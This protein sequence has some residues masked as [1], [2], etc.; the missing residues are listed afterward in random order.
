VHPE[1]WLP[2]WIGVAAGIVL[3][4]IP[5]AFAFSRP[6]S[7]L[8]RLGAFVLGLIVYVICPAIGVWFILLRVFGA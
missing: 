7:R 8:K 6:M 1:D 5:I 3:G 4:A 2:L